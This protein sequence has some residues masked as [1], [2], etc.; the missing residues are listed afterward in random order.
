MVDLKVAD[1]IAALKQIDAQTPGAANRAPRSAMA[2]TIK[3]LEQYAS[4]TVEQLEGQ[5][6]EAKP[7]ERAKKP[8]PALREELVAI[9]SSELKAAGT[10]PAQFEAVMT[11]LT[12]DKSAR[13]LEVKAIAKE[14]GASSSARSKP[15][16]LD[17][18][19]QKFE[20]RWKLDNRSTLNAS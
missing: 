20:E 7:P 5:L 6:K 3:H 14:Y 16:G 1:V 15:I 4:L 19:R 18:I 2:G 11:R 13:A 8:P 17:V 10:E 12:A 9:Y